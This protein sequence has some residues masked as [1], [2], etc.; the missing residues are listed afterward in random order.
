MAVLEGSVWVNRPKGPPTCERDA[1]A[2]R[3]RGSRGTIGPE[4]LERARDFYHKLLNDGPLSSLL[5]Y[6]LY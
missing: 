5:A 1:L 3:H 2:F 6:L 4:T